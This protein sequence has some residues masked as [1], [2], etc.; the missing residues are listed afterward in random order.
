MNFILNG[1]AQGNVASVLMANNFDAN[2][3]RPYQGRDGRS[4]ITVNTGRV[5]KDGKPIY[6][7][8]V[9]NAVATLRK[10][11]WVQLD[12]AIIKAA[13]P[14]LTAVA[15]LRAA[16]LQYVIPNGLGKTVLEHEAMSDIGDA[17]ISMDGLR[18]G[19]SDRPQFELTALPL[20]IVH[21][22]FQFSARQVMASR[23]GG[24]PLDTTNAE[25]AGRKVA[26]EVE[27]LLLGE[28]NTYTYGGGTVY[29]YTNFTDR[30]THT[31]TAPASDN[32]ATTVA[33]VLAM[34][35]KSIDAGY[36][37]PWAL[38]YSPGWSVYMDEDY[39]TS[40][41]DNTMRQR[42]A[43]IDGITAV[44]QADYLSD[45]TLLLVQMTS[46]VARMVIGMDLTTVQ[47]ESHGGMQLNFKVMCIM[48]PQLRSDYNDATGIV[49]GSV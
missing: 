4:Y 3:L 12:T 2:A 39:S 30:L 37:G 1:Q 7:A 21:K 16:G 23:N 18:E 32:H 20:P 28:V 42:L 49:H 29:G 6:Q 13:K 8:L 24:S 27:K 47:W 35:K 31:L 9:T 36:Y 48:V 45:T 40:K 22:D 25:L 43:A 14:R 38:Y 34:R 11:D 46:D 26:E 15:D 33:Q 44:K 5:D 17:S 10:D 19:D 41:G